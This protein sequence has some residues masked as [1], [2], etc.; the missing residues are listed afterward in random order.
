MKRVVMVTGA[1]RGIGFATAA[2]FIKN[3]DYVVIFCRHREHVLKAKKHLVSLGPP[4]NIL[5]LTGDVRKEKDARRIVRQCLKN[6]GRIDLLINNAGIA[7]YKPVEETSE[8]EWDDIID[9]NLK[10]TFL[11]TRQVLP[12]MKKQGNGMIINI[13]SALGKEGEANFSAYC[14]SKFGVLG[15]TQVVADETRESGLY[16]YAVLPWAVNTTLLKDSG[17]GLNSTEMLAPEY[18]AAKI[19][20]AAKGKKKSGTLFE[21]Y[22]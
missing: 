12:V 20:E 18:V 5:P 4:E 19:F 6:L 1:T 9:T 11:F 21:V 10:G 13:S 7:A 15:L 16:I 3:G 2:E 14:A 22:S 8:K 17:L